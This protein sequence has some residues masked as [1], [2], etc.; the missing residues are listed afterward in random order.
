M[1]GWVRFTY[2]EQGG[3]EEEVE[4]QKEGE[5]EEEGREGGKRRRPVIAGVSHTLTL[6]YLVTAGVLERALGVP[7]LRKPSWSIQVMGLESWP[8]GLL[9]SPWPSAPWPLWLTSG[10]P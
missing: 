4:E 7:A 8:K 10:F 6:P 3:G 1:C 2:V 5:E 9:P